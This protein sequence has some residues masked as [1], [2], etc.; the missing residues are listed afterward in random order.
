MNDK[1]VTSQYYKLTPKYQTRQLFFNLITDVLNPNMIV[2]PLYMHINPTTFNQGFQK[3]IQRYTTLNA[4]V[5][6]YWGE[7]LDTIS[8]TGSTGGFF[9]DGETEY[10]VPS[11]VSRNRNQ[12][13]SFF[14]FQDILDLYRNNGDVYDSNGRVIKKGHVILTFDIGTYYGYFENFN[15]LEDA[16]TPYRFTFDFS[17]KVEKSYLGF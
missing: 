10:D 5:E 6:E 9:L 17:Y 7:E 11:L 15:Y 3:K 13:K 4:F 12:T 1:K 8:C 16:E 14:K 2:P